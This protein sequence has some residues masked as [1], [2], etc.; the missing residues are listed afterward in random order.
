MPRDLG[1]T[2]IRSMVVVA[3]VL[4]P[5]RTWAET[6]NVPPGSSLDLSTDLVLYADDVLQ[7]GGSGGRCT[8]R[9]N[10]HSIRTAGGWTG[11]ALIS[12][13]DLVGVGTA[14][15]YALDLSG[16]GA[17]EISVEGSTFAQSGAVHLVT[18]DLT[19]VTFRGNTIL[20]SSLVPAVTGP[21]TASRPAFLAEGST[22]TAEKSFQGNQI[23]KSWVEFR[24]VRNWLIG[25]SVPA[26]SNVVIGKR[27]GIIIGLSQD[28]VVRGNYVHTLGD[29]VARA[30]LPPVAGWDQAFTFGATGQ[31]ILVEHNVMHGGNGLV[32]SLSG[33]ELRYNLLGDSFDLPW[34]ILGSGAQWSVH[35]NV[36]LRVAR[37]EDGG[38]L[39]GIQVLA[40]GP[41]MPSTQI[42]NNTM[43]G[44]GSC[45]VP[46]S[47]AIAIQ[48]EALLP[49][50]RNNA[51][52]RFRA[53]LGAATAMVR[54]YRDP[55]GQVEAKLTPPAVRLGYADYNLFYNLNAAVLDNYA[56]AVGGKAERVD[57]GFALNDVS[58]RG[59]IDQQA[60]PRFVGPIP[61]DL[62]Y[63]DEAIKAGAATVCQILRFYRTIYTPSADSPL[64]DR[65]DPAD[66]AGT[67]IGAVGAGVPR[68]DDL[69]GTL[70]AGGDI[71]TPSLPPSTYDC[72]PQPKPPSRPGGAGGGV[73]IGGDD[74]GGGGGGRE[75]VCVC[76]S[77]HAPPGPLI[78]S[79]AVAVALALARRRRRP[80]PGR[81]RSG[82][83]AT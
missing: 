60:D 13:C 83:A 8:I 37:T 50:L 75:I 23:L 44:G 22:G 53:D 61:Y 12:G 67:D 46:T 39:D 6:I 21:V 28:V 38:E 36:F 10:G 68:D 52:V 49:S 4:L 27:A 70:C 62:P 17:A 15:V 78:A 71:G 11:R 58:A 7:A 66:G 80:R 26:H 76:Q 19:T 14:E 73:G 45:R 1:V 81:R 64:I 48:A 79:L 77:A 56:V 74:D 9:G 55:E 20:E 16:S 59:A 31:R 18:E 5:C 43:D 40:D 35:H 29:D 25:G 42:Y 34:I 41:S 63:S 2:L 54:G 47:G 57:G 72:V 32:Q 51:I 30:G 65:G 69:F 82:A 33:A 3:V 24:Q